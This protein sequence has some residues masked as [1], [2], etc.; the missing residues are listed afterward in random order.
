MPVQNRI[1]WIAIAALLLTLP[2][3][4][5]LVLMPGEAVFAWRWTEHQVLVESLISIGFLVGAVV[6]YFLLRKGLQDLKEW[7]M[8]RIGVGVW[9]ALIALFVAF[10]IYM[11]NLGTQEVAATYETEDFTITAVQL[12]GGEDHTEFFV[13][14]SCAHTGPYKRLIYIDRYTGADEIEFAEASSGEQLYAHYSLEGREQLRQTYDLPE[15]YQQCLDSDS[16]RPVEN[17]E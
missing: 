7:R 1:V 17:M 13:V 10:T 16:P 3:W 5:D 8:I 11:Y 15:L 14:M 9:I 12:T 6:G 4:F 2:M